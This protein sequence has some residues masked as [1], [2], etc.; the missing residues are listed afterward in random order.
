MR[1]WVMPHPQDEGDAS[2]KFAVRGQTLFDGT[3]F[4]NDASKP[5]TL[6]QVQAVSPLVAIESP[7]TWQIKGKY[8]ESEYKTKTHKLADG[9]KLTIPDPPMPPA[10]TVRLPEASEGQS[11]Q[12]RPMRKWGNESRSNP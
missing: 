1:R 12:V 7:G 11:A 2:K 10:G 3:G 9:G 5:T 6:G 8:L 4:F